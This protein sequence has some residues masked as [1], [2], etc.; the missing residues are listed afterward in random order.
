ML[1]QVYS[2]YLNFGLV[3]VYQY[4]RHAFAYVWINM[5]PVYTICHN[6]GICGS[7]SVSIPCVL[8]YALEAMVHP[9]NICN[10]NCIYM[11]CLS[12]DSV[13]V[14]AGWTIVRKLSGSPHVDICTV[15]RRYAYECVA[16]NAIIV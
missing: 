8:V 9:R 7:S 11:V 15:Y 2:D 16:V 4:V 3:V 10:R 6:I 5:F 1:I 13:N 14:I 12:D